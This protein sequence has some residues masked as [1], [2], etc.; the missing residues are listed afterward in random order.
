MVVGGYQVSSMAVAI[1]MAIA[2]LEKRGVGEERKREG[3]AVSGRRAAG[4]G[5]GHRCPLWPVV[6]VEA[7]AASGATATHPSAPA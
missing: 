5:K 7:S 4:E 3:M 2:G 6:E 1:T